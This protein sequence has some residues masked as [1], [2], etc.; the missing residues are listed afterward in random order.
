M[1]TLMLIAI[2]AFAILLA[3][4][5]ANILSAQGDSEVQ[6]G[7]NIS[8]VP[9]NLEGLSRA[10]VA[11]GS[12]LVNAVAEC[13]RCHTAPPR[14]MPGFNPFLGEPA[15]VNT[16]NFLGR[17]TGSPRNLTPDAQ[18]HPAGLTLEEFI[19][20]MRT[21]TDLK[22]LSPFT[23]SATLDLLQGMP[24]PENLKMT[25]HDLRAIYEYLKAIPCVPGGAGLS[26]TRCDP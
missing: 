17:T 7:L 4:P 11:R 23:P 8:P 18:G 13:G 12:Y 21:G 10:L 6:R 15:Q 22:G 19:F 20:T 26:L 9:V 16:T 14:Y 5:Q 2:C 1:K 3:L 25:D 24:W